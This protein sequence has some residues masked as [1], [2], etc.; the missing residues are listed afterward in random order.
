MLK[1]PIMHMPE[2]LCKSFSLIG[3][4]NGVRKEIMSVDNNRKRSY[5]INVDEEF[6]KLILIPKENWGK[7]EKTAVISFDFE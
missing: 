3:E 1:S 6:N 4:K 2:T 5:H 7:K